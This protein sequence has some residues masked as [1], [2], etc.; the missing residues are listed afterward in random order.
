MAGKHYCKC[1]A[2][3]PLKYEK[4]FNCWNEELPNTTEPYASVKDAEE[5]DDINF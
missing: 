1:G 3:I 4:C 2:K 5:S